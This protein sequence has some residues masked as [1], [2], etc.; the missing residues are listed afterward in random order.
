VNASQLVH[1]LRKTAQ[2]VRLPLFDG[3]SAYDVAVFFWKG[4]YEGSVSSRAASISFSF[5]LALFP[6][7]IFLFTLIPFIP[8]AGFQS[9]LFKLLRDVLPPNSFDAAYT[10]IT[11]ILTIKRGDLLSVTVLAAFFFATNGTLS[12]IGNFG[13]SVH[14]LNVRGFW[15]QYLAAF[16]LTLA[17][18]VLLIV[19]ITVLTLSEVNLGEWVGGELGLWIAA[20]T[21]WIVLLGLVLL[22]IS[23]LFYFGPMRSAPWRFV[24]PGA[25][26]ATLLVWLTSYLFGIYVT[27]FSQ[28]N[29]LY[30]SIGTLMIIQLWLY[31]NAI[32]LIIGFEL[33][34]SMAEAKNYL[35]S[36]R[37]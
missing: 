34:A 17:L 2:N 37:T 7:V 10:T 19:G 32:G 18:S 36:R 27:D 1:V 14:R 35:L 26:L 30:G 8:V 20:A 15:S 31:V 29:Q 5:F 23:L 12:L 13:Q 21:R 9:E 6:G 3:L 25:L 33:N 16:L 28:Y 4:I 11:D 24:S 22:S